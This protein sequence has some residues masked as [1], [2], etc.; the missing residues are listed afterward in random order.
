[1]QLT[2]RMNVYSVAV[3]TT[4]QRPDLLC[5]PNAGQD[6]S[7]KVSVQPH[8]DSALLV[9]A[10][11]AS[12]LVRQIIAATHVRKASIRKASGGHHAIRVLQA[13][14]AST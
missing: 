7:L 12:A 5:V 13:A 8:P 10:S 11:L 9:I 1:M 3:D 4:S 14:T 2:E 6:T